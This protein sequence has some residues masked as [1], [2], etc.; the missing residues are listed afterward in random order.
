MEKFCDLHTHSNYSDGT[1]TPEELV[2]LAKKE[3]LSAIALTDHNTITGL[4]LFLKCAKESDGG[5][6]GT[7]YRA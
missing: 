6:C 1:L 4:P 7:R 3:N 5:F 2:A